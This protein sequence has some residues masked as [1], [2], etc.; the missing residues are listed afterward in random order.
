MTGRYTYRLGTQ[1]TV[2]RADVPFGVPLDNTFI[3]QNLKDVGYA[4]AL[5]G[6]WHLGFYQRAYTPLERGFDR[7]MGYYQG[8]VDYYSH[9]GG[10]YGGSQPGVDWHTGNETTNFDQSGTYTV[11]LIVPQTVKWLRER[12]ETPETPWFL[13]LPF[14][15]IHGPN[16]V[17][18]AYMALYPTLKPDQ[19]AASQDMCGVCECADPPRPS[20]PGGNANIAAT[21]PSNRREGWPRLNNSDDT[22]GP[23]SK[24]DSSQGTD[25]TWLQCHTVLAMAAAL[26]WGVGA[27]VDGLHA[28]NQW[29]NTIII[30]TSDNGAQGG[31][32]GTSFPLRGFKTQLYEG[33]VRVPGFVTGGSP[34]LPASVRGTL[35]NKLIHVVDWLPTIVG[36]AGGTTDRNKELDG[37]NVWDAITK[38]STPSPRT[39]ILLNINPACGLGF[40]NPNAALRVGDWKL[41]VDCF[42]VTTLAP[43]DNTKIELYN[44]A[45]DPYEYADQASAEPAMVK[46]LLLRMAHYGAQPDQVPPTLFPWFNK[47]DQGKGVADWNY[48]CPQCPQGGAKPSAKGFYF[49]PWCDD[50]TCVEHRP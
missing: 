33:G 40:V 9:V 27:V 4:T 8:C 45:K 29:N 12:A 38:P 22:S 21:M 28:T 3:P 23:E 34:L 6:K 10:G 35:N 24:A 25:V 11:E 17:P 31:Q 20:P 47:T 42:N 18:D 50:V 7:H 43:N 16:Q 13:Y 15:L 49:D 41:L 26:D 5:F 32:G 36:L 39:E 37:Y 19:T 46:Q 2:I 1:A 44:I 30:Y 48:Q 14:H